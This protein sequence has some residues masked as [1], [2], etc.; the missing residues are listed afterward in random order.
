MIPISIIFISIVFVRNSEWKNNLTLYETDSKKCPNNTRLFYFAGAQELMENRITD[1]PE[2]K[3][4]LFN[5]AMANLYK[6]ISIYPDY[7]LCQNQLA[8]VYLNLGQLDSAELHAKKAVKTG[9]LK[10]N[11]FNTLAN[12]Y[13]AQSK[14]DQAD[15][16]LLQAYFIDTSN[17]GYIFNISLCKIHQ[18]QYDSSVFYARKALVINPPNVKAIENLA[19]VFKIINENDSA[20][21][22]EYLARQ[23]EP[24]FSIGKVFLPSFGNFE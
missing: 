6:S 8:V 10:D 9:I 5:D 11:P 18:K 15:S 7:D 14:Y 13:M 3:K 19:Q 16:L 21:K 12:V 23:F 4:K 20:S 24:H 22:F 1:D 17:L 2:L